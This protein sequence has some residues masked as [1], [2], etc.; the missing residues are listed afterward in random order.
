MNF[1][2]SIGPGLHLLTE[3]EPE[4]SR[5]SALDSG[6]Q[7]DGTSLWWSRRF[8]SSR[9]RTDGRRRCAAA[10]A[11]TRPCP[12]WVGTAAAG[13]AYRDRSSARR[14]PAGGVGPKSPSRSLSSPPASPWAAGSESES[15]MTSLCDSDNLNDSQAWE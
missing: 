12:A 3:F 13:R 1:P 15:A 8:N 4:V 9:P 2:S 5:L 7:A 14:R 11:V 6:S 10:A